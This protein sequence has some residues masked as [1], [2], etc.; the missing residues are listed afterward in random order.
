[1]EVSQ[2]EPDAGGAATDAALNPGS[3]A[4]RRLI[5]HAQYLVAPLRRGYGGA[6]AKVATGRESLGYLRFCCGVSR[7]IGVL[8]S[9]GSANSSAIRFCD[10]FPNGGYGILVTCIFR[11]SYS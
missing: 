5:I 11:P 7:V 1:M 3:V 4:L 10:L 8:K 6:E 9:S 2:G